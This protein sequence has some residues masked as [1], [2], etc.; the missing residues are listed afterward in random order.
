MPISKKIHDELLSDICWVYVQKN[1]G[2]TYVIG[3]AYREDFF[4]QEVS[5]GRP[6]LLWRRFEDTLSAAGYRIILNNLPE[7]SLLREINKYKDTE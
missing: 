6:I 1:E 3:I 7:E 2:G 4:T 5:E